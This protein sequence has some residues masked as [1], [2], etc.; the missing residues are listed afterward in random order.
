[1]TSVTATWNVWAFTSCLLKC[2]LFKGCCGT[3]F[4]SQPY[5][6]YFFVCLVKAELMNDINHTW[7]WTGAAWWSPVQLTSSD[8]Q[9]W[10]HWHENHMSRNGIASNK[11]PHSSSLV[12]VLHNHNV[13]L[14]WHLDWMASHK[15]LRT[16]LDPL[17]KCKPILSG[18]CNIQRRPNHQPYFKIKEQ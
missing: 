6:F 13:I 15:G 11:V 9:R 12:P 3:F 7:N 4:A 16:E 5:Y 14:A 10:H 17:E 2:F 1:M 8:F 18:D